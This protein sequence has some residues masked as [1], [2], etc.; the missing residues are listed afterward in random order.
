M[1]D[2][3]KD[4]ELFSSDINNLTKHLPEDCVEYYLF[5]I[6][7]TTD[8]PSVAIRK[9][10]EDVLTAS[11]SLTASLLEDYIWQRDAF[12]LEFKQDGQPLT[13]NIIISCYTKIF[14]RR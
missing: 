13:F 3:P 14:R 7:S 9:A 1:A 10:L 12:K 6:P 5:H 8:D 11:T 4:P 2:G